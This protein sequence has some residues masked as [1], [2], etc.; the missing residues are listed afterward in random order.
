MNM[1]KTM[2]NVSL[3]WHS[4]FYVGIQASQKSEIVLELPT[5]VQS[6]ARAIDSFLR[7]IRPSQQMAKQGFRSI[8]RCSASDRI[9]FPGVKL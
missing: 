4:P 1:Q 3:M 9:R 5:Y 6:A 8:S 7:R 2:M